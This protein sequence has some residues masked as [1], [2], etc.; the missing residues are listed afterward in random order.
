MSLYQLVYISRATQPFSNEELTDL[1]VNAKN[2][3][4]SQDITGNLIYNGGMFLQVLEGDKKSVQALY[5]KIAL[6]SRHT[7]VRNI[8]FEPAEYRLFSRWSMNMV[9]LECDKPKN[10]QTI[11]DIIDAIDEDKLVDGMSPPV[12]LLKEFSTIR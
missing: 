9:N 11:K 6:D 12:K 7:K 2:N 4:S 10:I 8:Y 3:N 5:D 1:L